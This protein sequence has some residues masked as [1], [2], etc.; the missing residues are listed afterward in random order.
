MS[1][2]SGLPINHPSVRQI[3][4]SLLK[5]V[6]V[7]R[8]ADDPNRQV[9]D[10]LGRAQDLRSAQPPDTAGNPAY[11]PYATVRVG[12]TVV[13][14]IDNHGFATMSNAV[15]AKLGAGLPGHVN[16]RNGPELAQARA[17][18]IAERLGGRVEK[19]ASALT[20]GQF[21][22]IPRPGDTAGHQAAATGRSYEAL[23]KS[24]QA[25]TAFAAQ[26]I[27][28]SADADAGEA[29]D[30]ASDAPADSTSDAVTTFLEYMRMTPEERYFEAILREK[31][32][33]KEDLA[34]MP[35]EERERILREIREEMV[36]RMAVA[37][38]DRGESAES[39]TS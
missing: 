21:D 16:G 18:F 19:S 8:A 24:A 33:T 31:G 30:S 3:D 35:P 7:E 23:Q 4:I 39:P 34:N 27:A 38:A 12:G 32:L 17:E 36:N 10:A 28:Q 22:A 11:Q 13:A 2:I 20:Q 37:A 14:E 29:Q 5:P 6:P 25:Q 15:A 1:A 9:L 26:Q